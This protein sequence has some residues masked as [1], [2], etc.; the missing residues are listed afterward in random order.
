MSEIIKGCL[1]FKGE[2]G[3]HGEV[4][5]P[6]PYEGTFQELQ[7]SEED[8]GRFYIIMDEQDEVYYRHWVYYDE[9]NE[10]WKDGGEYLADLVINLEDLTQEEWESLKSN[11]T[12]YYKRYESVYTTT[13][14]NETNIPINISQY[15]TL[16]IL[17]VYIE[18][19]VLN[20][21]EYAINGTNSI[22]LNIP[23]SEIGTKVH[24]IVYRSVCASNED[25]NELKG[26]K[27][28]S[29]AIVFDTI[30]EMKAD[31]DLVA[32]DTCQ[33]L[34]Y[35]SAN[36][37]G[38]G[39]YKIVY[40]DTLISDNCNI[41]DLDNGLKANL[42]NLEKMLD[43]AT[44][45][46]QRIGRKIMYG[47]SPD[48]IDYDLQGAAIGLQGGC[49]IN[50]NTIV[51]MLWDS[52]NPNLNKNKLVLMNINT[53]VI[54]NT[55][56][57]NFGWCNSIA[58]NNNLLYVAVRGTTTNDIATN[59][60][61]IKIINIDTLELVDE[62]TL[63]FNVNAI[64][65]HNN[66]LYVLEEGSNIIHLYNH[67]GTSKNEE[68]ELQIDIDNLYNQNIKVTYKYIYLLS[69]KP[70]NLLTV[71]D[72]LGKK[73]QAYNVPKYA[74][75]YRIGE[76]QFIDSLDGKNMILGSTLLNYEEALNQFF[77][78]NLI[79]NISTNKFIEDYAQT[80]YCNPDVDL[81]NPDGTKGNE[82]TTINE[83]DALN[84]DNI[85]IDVRDYTNKN[86]KYTH[87]SNHKYFR[88]RGA[89]FIEGLY[90]QYGTYSLYETII[91]YSKRLSN[92]AVLYTRGSIL[93]INS[94]RLDGNGNRYLIYSDR[95]NIIKFSAP[96]FEN[97]TEKVFATTNPDTIVEPNTLNTLPFLNRAKGIYNLCP[98]WITGW[99]TGHI[100]Y[101]TS[102]S[103]KE[104]QTI[105]DNC[106]KIILGITDLN[107]GDTKEIKI[108]KKSDSTY[109][110]SAEVSSSSSVN[111]RIAK[112][113]ILA[114][115]QGINININCV[116]KITAS[117]STVL[118]SDD[119]NTQN[120]FIQLRYIGF[121]NE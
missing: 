31:E 112:M 99:K 70:S 15:N 56:D 63:P 101:T 87:L 118:N 120:D 59:N 37:G 16:A 47:T 18:G 6:I 117:G 74:G 92:N 12:N 104:I 60:G 42:I 44:F 50:S 51:F 76:L 105:I 78:F 55:A 26:P 23:L 61:D 102:L 69:T 52:L 115:S 62:Y 108:N 43:G 54:Q 22:T 65:I 49:M 119:S 28:D 66:T 97:Y 111:V 2:K 21:N 1:G 32:G 17:E 48:S 121:S 41:I 113:I 107:S 46:L 77:K 106:N 94:T 82:F 96:Q 85:I 57:F 40:D 5:T 19:R 86:F 71:Y 38:A 64:S 100:D 13:Q 109:T 72:K 53:G 11:L 20:R 39:L 116:T 58:Y 81:Y 30:A 103:E 79:N 4:G 9:E 83:V 91:N 75:R 27:G 110:I 36:D 68:I 88:I 25:L 84:I 35:Y 45:D 3:E 34:G 90:C 95:D 14:A 89:T 73:I 8:K 7:N 24:F 80:I 67:N 93:Y 29:G 114:N 10:Q 33:T 98:T